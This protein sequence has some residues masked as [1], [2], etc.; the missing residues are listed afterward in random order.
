M[1]FASSFATPNPTSC[2]TRLRISSRS[3]RRR[4]QGPAGQH[5][6]PASITPD[7]CAYVLSAAFST[8][9]LSRAARSGNVRARRPAP[10][11]GQRER[12]LG[13]P[14]PARRQRVSAGPD[15]GPGAHPRPLRVRSTKAPPTEVLAAGLQER[16]HAPSPPKQPPRPP[17][18]ASFGAAP[19]SPGKSPL[20]FQRSNSPRLFGADKKQYASLRSQPCKTKDVS[21][22]LGDSV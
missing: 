2:S 20:L 22:S 6:T 7:Q 14:P 13:C 16:D 10:S 21:A 5:A 9:R 8:T 19:P 17:I 18:R 11:G 4:G 15:E 1:S 3:R 12:A